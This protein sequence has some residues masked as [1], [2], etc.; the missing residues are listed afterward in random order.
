M[1][2]LERYRQP[3]DV[4]A[5]GRFHSIYGTEYFIA[6]LGV[7]RE[8]VRGLIGSYAEYLVY[9]FCSVRNRLPTFVTNANGYPRNV[10]RDL[11]YIELANLE[12]Q[13]KNGKAANKIKLIKQT[14]AVLK[15]EAIKND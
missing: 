10:Q 14:L 1:R 11:L 12:D 15:E 2:I 7:T 6:D 4:C 5:A 3:K 8:M 13:N 9:E